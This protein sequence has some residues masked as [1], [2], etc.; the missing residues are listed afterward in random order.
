MT[1]TRAEDDGGLG[2][3]GRELP[4]NRGGLCEKG[5]SAAELLGHPDRLTLDGSASAQQVCPIRS[6]QPERV[7][8]PLGKLVT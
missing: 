2:G 3:R 6:V 8:D 5:L 4:T 1:V 7:S